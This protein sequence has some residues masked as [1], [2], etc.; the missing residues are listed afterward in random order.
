MEL[1]TPEILYQNK[2]EKDE[3]KTQSSRFANN[4]SLSEIQ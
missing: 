3:Q 1:N 4:I 2:F